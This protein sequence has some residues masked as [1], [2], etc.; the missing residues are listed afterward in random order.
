MV[1]TGSY[2][3]VPEDEEVFFSY[4]RFFLNPNITSKIKADGKVQSD[5]N[6]FAVHF[7]EALYAISAGDIQKAEKD[8]LKARDIWPEYYG[9]YFL[10]ARVYE[11]TGDY[12]TAARYYRSYLDRLRDFYAGKYRISGPIIRSL[13]SYSIER[14]EPARE[15]ISERMAVYG[16]DLDDVHPVFII[17][18]FLLPLLAAMMLGIIWMM[19]HYKI[20]PYLKRK[21]RIR[22]IP[23]GFWVCEYCGNIN[24]V[25]SKECG[26]C[27]RERR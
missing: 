22:N 27:K 18:E 1:F 24:P 8:L 16:I 19:F 17:P 4:E 26:E 9:T 11:Q 10:L 5:L 23:E 2:A 25:L 15:L 14:Y 21:R 6:D 3:A 20:M 7:T 12:G 13:S